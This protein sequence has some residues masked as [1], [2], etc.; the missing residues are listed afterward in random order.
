MKRFTKV[1]FMA[2]ALAFITVP[3]N[4]FAQSASGSA[5]SEE[6]DNDGDE[7]TDEGDF[8]EEEE[9][10]L[11]QNGAGDQYLEVKL[12]PL[13]PLNF[14]DQLYT[15][16]ALTIGYHRFLTQYLAVGGNAMFSYNST[17]GSNILTMIP[18]TANVTFQPYIGKFEFPMTFHIGAVLENYVQYKY[19]PGLI[20]KF[21]AGCYYRINESW[22]AGVE[23]SLMWL[24]Q[25]TGD[26]SKNGSY[27][28]LAI[29]AGARYHF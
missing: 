1:I 3:Q 7:Y 5:N 19:F 22:S 29:M 16:G 6:S 13:F 10:R 15:G 27:M 9:E 11:T 17:I 14:D 20:L 21:D 12:M 2:C 4:I 23:G 18:L 26:S 24:P 25:W 8:Y 28:G